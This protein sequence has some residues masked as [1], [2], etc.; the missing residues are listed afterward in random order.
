[1]SKTIRSAR[2]GNVTVK[3]MIADFFGDKL[4][5]TRDGHPSLVK[6]D[7]DRMRQQRRNQRHQDRHTLN[8][9]R[10]GIIDADEALYA[11]RRHDAYDLPSW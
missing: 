2:R 5:L 4:D 1:M 11:D 8:G 6:A 9:I 10:Q 7:Q 3:D